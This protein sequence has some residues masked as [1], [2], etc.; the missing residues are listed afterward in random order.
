MN[1]EEKVPHHT[2]AGM[3]MG[4]K[5][6]GDVWN[7]FRAGDFAAYATIYKTYFRELLRYGKHLC[8]DHELLKDCIQDI[9]VKMWNNR[10]NLGHTSNIRYYLFTS[11]K[12]KIIDHNR[13]LRTRLM[14]DDDISQMEVE[15]REH[16]EDEAFQWQRDRVLKSMTKLSRHQQRVLHL[17]FYQNRSNQE[18]ASELGI[19]IQSVY[20]AVFKTLRSIREELLV[21]ILWVIL[22]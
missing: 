12:Y 16:Q 3:S 5:A 19:T 1:A 2:A 11:L 8:D 10:Q 4:P 21:L 9:F 6:D 7:D 14:S 18:I 22:L 17:K 20:N 15:D 13:A